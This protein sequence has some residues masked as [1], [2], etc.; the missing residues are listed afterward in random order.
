MITLSAKRRI[1]A[2]PGFTFMELI[3]VVG[4]LA[5]LMAVIGNRI[6]DYRRRTNVG[7]AKLGLRT[8][9]ESIDFYKTDTD[10]YPTT[11]TDLMVKPDNVKNWSSAYISDKKSLVD[12]WGNK[13]KYESTPDAEH[14]YELFSQGEKG[15]ASTREQWIS[16]WDAK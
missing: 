10:Q 16:V 15:R 5:T 1:T 8:I 12:P 2:V 7:T 14:P 13:Y 6:V 11:L 3:L 4:I 9:Q